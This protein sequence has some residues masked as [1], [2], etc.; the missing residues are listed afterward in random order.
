MFID[1]EVFPIVMRF[2]HRILQDFLKKHYPLL[3]LL[4]KEDHKK[5]DKASKVFEEA[6]KNVRGKI[7]CVTM[8]GD[9]EI[10]TTLMEVFG[11][12]SENLPQVIFSSYFSK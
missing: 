7:Q 3:V 12:K 1:I 8:Y 11:I 2:Q 4:K 6:C 10:E 9:D 5:S